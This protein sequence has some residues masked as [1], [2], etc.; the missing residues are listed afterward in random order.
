MITVET[1]DPE[2]REMVAI[3][4]WD[5]SEV[6]SMLKVH[7]STIRK[8]SRAGVARPYPAHGVQHFNA[9]DLAHFYAALSGQ[10]HGDILDTRVDG[11]DVDASLGTP[12]TD[13]DLEGLR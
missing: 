10:D 13:A 1:W 4:Y 9:T 5:A 3:D 8:L 6:A 11:L 7:P 12:V 2:R